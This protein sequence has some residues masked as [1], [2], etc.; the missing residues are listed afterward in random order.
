MALLGG[1]A[2]G[3]AGACLVH[4]LGGAGGA[5]HPALAVGARWH[6]GR[7]EMRVPKHR[8]WALTAPAK[9]AAAPAAA[10]RYRTRGPRPSA[11]LP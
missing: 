4:F 7:F 2:A 6:V 8:T 1:F 3:A 5:L 11:M 10:A 9:P